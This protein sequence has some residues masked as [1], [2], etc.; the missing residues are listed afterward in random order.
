M[1]G[2]WVFLIMIAS[3]NRFATLN[4]TF[5]IEECCDDHWAVVEEHASLQWPWEAGVSVQHQTCIIWWWLT[6]GVWA[7]VVPWPWLHVVDLEVECGQ[8]QYR[9]VLILLAVEPLYVLLYYHG[10][11]GLDVGPSAGCPN[12]PLRYRMTR[13]TLQGPHFHC[14]WSPDWY[15]HHSALSES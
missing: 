2:R 4:E 9:H 6:F 7:I 10:V 14:C 8:W 1:I 13:W 15:C 5:G 3:M 11:R 12:H